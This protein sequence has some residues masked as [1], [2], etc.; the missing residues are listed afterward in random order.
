MCF[1]E[2]CERA[3]AVSRRNR[4]VVARRRF[5]LADPSGW[6]KEFQIAIVIVI[7]NRSAS[8]PSLCLRSIVIHIAAVN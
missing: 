6:Q 2:M 7:I 8:F 5:A 1:T 3:A 4:N